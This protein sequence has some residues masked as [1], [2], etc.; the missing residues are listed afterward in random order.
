[1]VTTSLDGAH[2]HS[3]TV[4]STSGRL[5]V[6][7]P[8]Y[9]AIGNGMAD[10]SAAFRG[11]AAAAK[12]AISAPHSTTAAGDAL[13]HAIIEI[14]PGEYLITDPGAMLGD[15]TM[16]GRGTGLRF[17]GDGQSITT[18]IFR[19]SAASAMCSN[20]WWLNVSF[21]GM[22]IIADRATCTFLES[23]T[24]HGAQRYT[25]TDVQFVNFRR[26]YELQGSNNNSE[27]SF[28]SCHATG[29]GS[30]EADKRDG[31]WH[32][33]GPTATTD[34]FLNYSWYS[35]T[36]W[37]TQAP[38]IDSAMGGHFSLYSC[39]MSDFGRG[40]TGQ[41]YAFKLLG[42]TH[43]SG[44]CTFVSHAFRM[45]GLSANTGL[46]YSEWPTGSVSFTDLD[47]ASGAVSY[48]YG[49]AVIY[50]KYVNRRGPTYTFRGGDIAGGLT[51]EYQS[52]DFD[53]D[54]KIKFEGMSWYQQNDPT[55]VV[56]YVPT[57]AHPNVAA[58]PVQFVDCMSDSPDGMFDAAGQPIWDATVGYN[59]SMFQVLTKRE[60]AIRAPYGGL[61]ITG[62]NESVRLPLGALITDCE[63]L[64]PL[65]AVA[66]SDGGSYTITANAG[67]DTIATLTM[68][69][70]LS[71][72]FRVPVALA[73]PY[74]CDSDAKRLVKVV[75]TNI[76]VP[77]LKGL[78]LIKGYW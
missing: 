19:P 2:T 20:D 39:D 17:I 11:A 61:Q 68:P 23:F 45:E 13:G 31:A 53:L 59:R 77:N 36:N 40:S 57:G 3:V 1:M 60:L 6:K 34:Q 22:T 8:A 44:T 70:A 46:L 74:A 5:N 33:V 50:I 64:S 73:V 54:H 69:T 49:G 72:G 65:N 52:S 48:T 32:F 4:P 43:A 75:P 78:L 9:G 58:P 37:S 47:M 56:T 66:E 27:F 55:D 16:T 67:V 76:A 15:E 63:W 71:A 29:I 38:W 30:L 25:F 28:Y 14:P 42:I 18:L 21:E 7:D 51:V 35:C 24:T 26:V 62:Y 41:V 12:A 10:E